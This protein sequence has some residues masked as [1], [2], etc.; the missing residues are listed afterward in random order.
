MELFWESRFR[1]QIALRKG[2]WHVFARIVTVASLCV[3]AE[4]ESISE[5]LVFLSRRFQFVQ[6]E[7]LD[8]TCYALLPLLLFSVLNLFPFTELQDHV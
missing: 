4:C 6:S 8:A 7:R 3:A 2:K 1:I 5:I